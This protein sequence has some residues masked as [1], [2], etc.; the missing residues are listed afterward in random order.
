[1]TGSRRRDFLTGRKQCSNFGNV[2]CRRGERKTS[3]WMIGF[4]R[5]PMDLYTCLKS[6]V[7]ASGHGSSSRCKRSSLAAAWC[8][9]LM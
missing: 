9:S 1:M 4:F 8:P 5:R 6:R 7:G 3:V 2:V